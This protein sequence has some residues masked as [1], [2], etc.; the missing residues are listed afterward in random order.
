MMSKLVGYIPGDV[1]P[2]DTPTGSI[3]T[4]LTKFQSKDIDDA[5]TQSSVL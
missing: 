3:S 4:E 5:D 1:H 2:P